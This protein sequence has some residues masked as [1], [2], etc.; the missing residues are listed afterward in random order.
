MINI[1]GLPD[2]VSGIDVLFDFTMDTPGFWE[3]F[4]DRREG[5][6]AGGADPDLKSQTLRRYHQLLC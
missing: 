3:G 4:W 2:N 6:G 5:L 1:N